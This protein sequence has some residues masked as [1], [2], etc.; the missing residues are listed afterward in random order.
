MGSSSG[1]STDLRSWQAQVSE[2]PRHALLLLLGCCELKHTAALTGR[3][4]CNASP[5]CLYS[6]IAELLPIDTAVEFVS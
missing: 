6:S 5:L 1:L 2:L 3:Y 4:R